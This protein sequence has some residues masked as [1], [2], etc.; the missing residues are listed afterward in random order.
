MA[1]GEVNATEN[2]SILDGVNNYVLMQKDED[3]TLTVCRKGSNS[4]VY[5]HWNSF[6]P[7]TLFTLEL[8]CTNKIK[9]RDSESLS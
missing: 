6:V 3:I 8:F 2:V 7:I 5:L 1:S 4:Y 9:Q